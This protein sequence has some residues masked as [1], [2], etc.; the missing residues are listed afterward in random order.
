ME[1][2]DCGPSINEV[3]NLNRTVHLE[4]SVLNL[5]PQEVEKENIDFLSTCL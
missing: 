3:D 2:P 4:N 1:N 5:G